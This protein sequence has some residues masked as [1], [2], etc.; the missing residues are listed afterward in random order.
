LNVIAVVT[1]AG[2]SGRNL[3][4]PGMRDVLKRLRRKDVDGVLVA[5][6]DRLSRSIRDWA[7][8]VES[9]F[10][11]RGGKQLFSVNECVD[12][13]T[14]NGR[15]FLNLIV[16]IAQ[17]E[18]EQ[19]SE[20]TRVALQ[21]KIAKGERCGNLPMGYRL[22]PDGIHL[23]KDAREQRTLALMSD[24]RANG[25]TYQAVADELN[26]RGAKRR[27]GSAWT[28]QAVRSI[29]LLHQRRSGACDQ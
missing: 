7:S 25:L 20:R 1:D 15:F 10:S 19:I 2:E 3:D 8:L 23:V 14:A 12:T 16:S 17:W 9:H 21:H 22:G 26:R 11:E 6:L 24:L 18:R 29:L 28:H 27:H 13:R 4:R 5:K